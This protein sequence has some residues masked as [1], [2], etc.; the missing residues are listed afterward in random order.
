MSTSRK[1][2]VKS[3]SPAMLGQVADRFKALAEPNRLLLLQALQE[4]EQAVGDLVARTGLSLANASKQ[5]QQLHAAGFIQRRKDGL[6]VYYSLS[7]LDVMT[8]CDLM[9]GRVTRDAKAQERALRAG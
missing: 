2:P 5:L 9:C 7:D 6:F 3:L 4:G 8:L 1:R